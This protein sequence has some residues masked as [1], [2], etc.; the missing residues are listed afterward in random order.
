[1]GLYE[2]I[3][4]ACD[5]RKISINQMEKDLGYSRSSINKFNTKTPSVNKIKEIATYLNVSYELLIDGQND[6][7]VHIPNDNKDLESFFM[8]G[9][10]KLNS[11]GMSF[12]GVVLD[13][14]TMEL[15]INSMENGM[16]IAKLAAREKFTPKKYLNGNDQVQ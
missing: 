6:I 5:I 12:N 13:D 15:L 16:K 8:N 7:T 1:M 9:I 14:E 3:K 2:N 11:G 4:D 10:E